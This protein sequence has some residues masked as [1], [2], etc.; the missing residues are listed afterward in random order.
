MGNESI[1]ADDEPQA[2]PHWASYADLMN[3]R[4]QL[5][6]THTIESRRQRANFEEHKQDI[7]K[8]WQ[9]RGAT[10]QM[11]IAH[12]FMAK[13]GLLLC[14][15][16]ES[17]MAEIE[18]MGFKDSKGQEIKLKQRRKWNKN[19]TKKDYRSAVIFQKVLA[20][21]FT[22]HILRDPEMMVP[23]FTYGSATVSKTNWL[24]SVKWLAVDDDYSNP[25]HIR[26]TMAGLMNRIFSFQ[27][28]EKVNVMQRHPIEWDFANQIYTGGDYVLSET[29]IKHEWM[30][31][32]LLTGVIW[33]KQ[34]VEPVRRC[35]NLSMWNTD[36]G[37]DDQ[38]KLDPPNMHRL[39]A[40]IMAN[41]ETSDTNNNKPFINRDKILI[42][43]NWYRI[44]ECLNL[45]FTFQDFSLSN[46]EFTPGGGSFG[47]RSKK[48]GAKKGSDGWSIWLKSFGDKY[49]PNIRM[50]DL[51]TVHAVFSLRDPAFH[52]S[53]Y[54]L[55]IYHF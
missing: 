19:W 54:Q 1:F 21:W 9:T 37:F 5:D 48:T 49:P 40:F 52:H 28:N 39:T 7:N 17:S 34:M 53:M 16:F 26:K 31:D 51:L 41:Y 29:E 42:T 3:I 11:D 6:Y 2:I 47:P 13:F 20:P 43:K 18:Q 14:V 24:R 12:K 15:E 45:S 33:N 35:L 8:K 23:I 44:H 4:N 27:Q 55:Y 10:L 22:K 46:S 36:S 38:I 32:R 25:V 50:S 30:L